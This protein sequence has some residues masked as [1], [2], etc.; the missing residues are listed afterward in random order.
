MQGC[1]AANEKDCTAKGCCWY[2][3]KIP[4][5]LY[6]NTVKLGVLT[7]P[8]FALTA[9]L[10]GTSVTTF[11][12]L[13]AIYT[14][15]PGSDLQPPPGSDAAAGRK[16][17]SDFVQGLAQT[18]VIR[19]AADGSGTSIDLLKAAV[20][21]F[22]TTSTAPGL[23]EHNLLQRGI[24]HLPAIWNLYDVPT[25]LVVQNPLSATMTM[26]SSRCDIIPCN[27]YDDTHACTEYDT[28]AVGWYTDGTLKEVVPAKGSKQ[29]ASHSVN[30]YSILSPDALKTLFDAGDAGA[31]IRLSGNM[32]FL[33]G[34]CAIAVDY[35]QSGVPVCLSYLG[36]SC[37]KDFAEKALP[38]PVNYLI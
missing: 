34:T 16:F 31:V 30:M 27:K 32:T 4:G 8:N 17:L 25:D 28:K 24:M 19:G 37:N 38:P 36:H 29:L 33:V 23:K 14:K 13:K 7:I 5:C 1:A 18:V 21:G 12:K 2:L 26:T 9:N 10:N 6:K 3:Q 15:P 22:R 11:S 35:S 20:A